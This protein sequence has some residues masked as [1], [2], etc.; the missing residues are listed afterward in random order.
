[1][2]TRIPDD[3]YVEVTSLGGGTKFVLARTGKDIALAEASARYLAGATTA[4]QF[5]HEVAAI[6]E[7]TQTTE[8][9]TP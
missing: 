5:E 2:P 9:G 8:G 4:D 6:L 1:M 3:E 7:A